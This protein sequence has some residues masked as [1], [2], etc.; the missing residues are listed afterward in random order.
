MEPAA[1]THVW[2]LR[3]MTAADG[4]D[5]ARIYAEGIATGIGARGRGMRHALVERRSPL[6]L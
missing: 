2:S 4:P 1:A 3:D 5:V 6:S